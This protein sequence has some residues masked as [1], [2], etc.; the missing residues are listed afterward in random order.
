MH[1]YRSKRYVSLKI[2]IAFSV[3]H[4][5][6]VPPPSLGR[7]IFKPYKLYS[8]TTSEYINLF[9][10][11]YQY[12]LNFCKTRGVSEEEAED[13]TLHSFYIF[14]RGK[15]NIHMRSARTYL[16]TLAKNKCIDVI[17]RKYI[18]KRVYTQLSYA[19]NYIDPTPSIDLKS[20]TAELHDIIESLPPKQKEYITLRY[21]DDISIEK[22][23]RERKD[24]NRNTL[25]NT[26]K[27]AS[28]KIRKEL[29]NRGITIG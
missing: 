8:M 28:D 23:I 27:R 14:W 20:I 3:S 11:Q 7:G 12:L 6:L 19:D 25:R 26:L 10:Q 5:Q 9:H 16:F 24:I 29:K 21:L 13:I 2:R 17:R 22:I 1:F 15:E 4:V 18:K